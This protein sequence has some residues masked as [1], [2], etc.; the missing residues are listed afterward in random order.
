MAHFVDGFLFWVHFQGAVTLFFN[1]YWS[2]PLLNRPNGTES[3]LKQRAGPGRKRIVSE[4]RRY[5]RSWTHAYYNYKII[6]QY[7]WAR[8]K[9]LYNIKRVFRCCEFP[10]KWTKSWPSRMSIFGTGDEIF[11]KDVGY[12]RA[13]LTS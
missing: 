12:K 6:N 1:W 5:W 11:F 2:S 10:I 9:Y 8:I 3:L 4:Q 7:F 13:F